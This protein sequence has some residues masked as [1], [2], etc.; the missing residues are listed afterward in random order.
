MH[1]THDE[2]PVVRRAVAAYQEMKKGHKGMF[3]GTTADEVLEE[4]K[5]SPLRGAEL[6]AFVIKT[7]EGPRKYLAS[8]PCVTAMQE[9]FSQI[10]CEYRAARTTDIE[11]ILVIIDQLGSTLNIVAA[12]VGCGAGRY[13]ELLFRFLGEKLFLYCA[14]VNAEMLGELDTYLTDLGI[15]DFETHE[16]SAHDLPFAT[17]S[18]DCIFTF[19][20]CHRFDLSVFVTEAH[21]AL[22]PGGRLFMYTRTRTQHARSVWGGHFPSF[23]EKETRLYTNDEVGRGVSGTR[24]MELT[25]LRTFRYCHQRREGASSVTITYLTPREPEAERERVTP[26]DPFP[27]ESAL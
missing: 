25:D 21:R 10:A 16:A 15:K 7:A 23:S 11:P 27:F 17:S 14:D 19:N 12:D 18:L 1:L 5:P 26:A 24:G 9:H 3:Q 6:A 13:D 20:A 22:K 2:Q 4:L 8:R